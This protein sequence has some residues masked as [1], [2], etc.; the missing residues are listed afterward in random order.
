MAVDAAVVALVAT[1]LGFGCGSGRSSGRGGGGGG[2]TGEGEG[3]GPA[4][5]EGEGEGPAEGEG[6]GPAEGEGEGPAEGE[7]EGPAEGEGEGEGE[8]P[9]EGEGEGEGPAEGEGEGDPAAPRILSFD[10]NVDR[11]TAGESVTFTAVVTDPDGIEDLIGGSLQDPDS[12]ATY[13]AFATSAGEGAYSA[14]LSWGEL[15]QV[16]PIEFAV[17]TARAFEAVFFDVAGS[18]ATSRIEV[19]LHCEGEGACDGACRDLTTTADCGRCD[20]RCRA[21]NARCIDGR[22]G[23]PIGETDCGGVCVDTRTSVAHCGGCESPCPDAVGGAPRCEAGRCADPCPGEPIACGGR[24]TD[25]VANNDHCG[26]CD[27]VCPSA[28]GGQALCGAGECQSPCPG[29]ETA[30]DFVCRHLASDAESCGACGADCAAQLARVVDAA[31][32][33]RR[34]GEALSCQG[35]ECIVRVALGWG[36][37]QNVARTDCHEVCGAY[38]LRCTERIDDWDSCLA[39]YDDIEMVGH[40]G[41]HCAVYGYANSPGRVVG[42]GETCDTRI[43]GDF[44]SAQHGTL[45]LNTAWCPCLGS[46]PLFGYAALQHPID[47]IEVCGEEELPL[48]FGRVWVPDVT[49]GAGQGEGVAAELGFGPPGTNPAQDGRWR[50]T[51]G[52]YQG[53]LRNDFGDLAD[54]EYRATLQA[55]PAGLHVLAWR[56]RLDEGAW[57]YGDHGPGGSADGYSPATTTLVRVAEACP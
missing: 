53:D 23:C 46:F 10:T 48:V 2:G 38:G 43:R 21:A 19:T 1:L 27:L 56:F 29:G 37:G 33:L 3:E 57:F 6:E 42:W 39:L 35:G 30:C 55:V 31:D 9:A 34:A 22:C 26:E 52:E 12:G 13:G 50:W 41:H 4:E 51:E 28:Q 5:G 45:P 17:D 14:T 32:D 20:N 54:D 15:H 40:R 7:G 8:G 47:P 18:R 44:N 49:Q 11:L 24:C 36:P 25:V 16:R